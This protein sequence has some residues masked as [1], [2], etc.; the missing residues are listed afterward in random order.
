MRYSKMRY[1]DV[2]KLYLKICTTSHNLYLKISKTLSWDISVPKYEHI[3]RYIRPKTNISWT[4]SED[5]Q[6]DIARYCMTLPG[7]TWDN[8]RYVNM[9][10]EICHY[11]PRCMTLH[12]LTYLEICMEV[13]WIGCLI[14]G[15]TWIDL[16]SRLCSGSTALHYCRAI[17]FQP[18]QRLN[19][20]KSAVHVLFIVGGLI[21]PAL[22][23]GRTGA[24]GFAAALRPRHRHR[25]VCL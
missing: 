16:H 7:I 19:L 21:R 3:L 18:F 4:T 1:Q 24:A 9:Y 6:Q 15:F 10:L 14:S 20:L 22:C 12:I 5:M 2:H 17:P 13:A 23:A 25:C 11:I 8:L